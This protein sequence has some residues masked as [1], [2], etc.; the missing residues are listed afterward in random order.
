MKKFLLTAAVVVI[1]LGTY[2]LA[3]GAEV[4]T[5]SDCVATL[6]EVIDQSQ[7]VYPDFIAQPI[8][9]EE[10]AAVLEKNGPPPVDPPYS[11]TLVAATVDGEQV[12][13]LLIH[14]GDCILMR[15][16]PGPLTDLYKFLGRREASN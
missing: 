9:A 13:A 2:G 15:V 4:S 7:K 1:S 14:D 8:S 16:G 3:R 6:T 5:R 10:L 12:G 11:F